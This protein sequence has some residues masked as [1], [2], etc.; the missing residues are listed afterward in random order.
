M[1][2]ACSPVIWRAFPATAELRPATA[3]LRNCLCARRGEGG[4]RQ[5]TER[6]LHGG[7]LGQPARS[8]V[9]LDGVT[10]SHTG[11]LA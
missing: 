10:D 6:A 5:F 8:V 7:V 11:H 3:E 2:H 4:G 9:D 1:K